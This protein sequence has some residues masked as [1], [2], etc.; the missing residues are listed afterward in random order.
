M[1]VLLSGV[2]RFHGATTILSDVSLALPAGARVGVVGPNGVGKSTLLRLLA[3]VDEPDAGRVDREPA[4]ARRRLPAAGARAA[5]RRD[6][7]R[8]DSRAAPAWPP[9][10]GELEAAAAR[11]ATGDASAEAAYGE[12]LDRLVALGGGDLDARAAAT[13]A[14]ARPRRRPRPARRAACRAARRRARR[15]RRSSSPASTCSRWTSRRTTS[16]STASSAWSGSCA[17][18]RA[19]LSSSRTTASSS[20]ARSSRVVEIEPVTRH[21]REFAGGWSGYAE[22][23]ERRARGGLGALRPGRPAAPA[24]DRAAADRRTQAAGRRRA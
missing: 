17:A 12:A 8:P 18:S 5:A 11:L 15:W 22:R 6:A 20:I 9:P 2:S 19:A 3:G 13:R 1:R 4:D 7:A 14:R 10:S 23:R 24:S 16:T 21:A